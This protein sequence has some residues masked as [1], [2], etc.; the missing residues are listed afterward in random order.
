MPSTVIP[1]GR[2]KALSIGIEYRELGET[3]PQFRLS[4]T[5]KDPF[6]MSRLLQEHYGYRPEDITILTDE[7]SSGMQPT[8]ENIMNCMRELV[9]DALPGDRLVFHFS[10]HGSQLPAPPEHPEETD[11]YDEVIWPCDIQA[12]LDKDEVT[13]CILDN[14]IKE[15]LIDKLPAGVR[16]TL[17]LDC[18]SSG[19]GADLPFSSGPALVSSPI[20][21]LEAN[22]NFCQPMSIQG[23]PSPVTRQRSQ[24]ITGNLSFGV[25]AFLRRPKR[26]VTLQTLNEM[27]SGEVNLSEW[28]IVTCW[29]ACLDDQGTLESPRGSI[30]LS[31]S[32]F[33]SCPVPV[34]QSS[35]WF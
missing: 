6:V 4:G 35:V 24:S 28:P 19:T 10:G 32:S 5:H 9:R 22:V 13:N 20:Q 34:S 15:I 1:E 7:K 31:V 11:G 16:L 26:R 21:P 8:K 23:P 12:Y 3:L 17:L 30:F 33:F 25:E 18:C 29:A 27:L 14:D 2:R